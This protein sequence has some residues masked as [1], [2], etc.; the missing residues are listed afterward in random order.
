MEHLD[1]KRYKALR[2]QCQE[3]ALL[4]ALITRNITMSEHFGNA[5]VSAMARSGDVL[6][7]EELCEAVQDEEC[8]VSTQLPYDILSDESGAWED[9]C[10][11][12]RG[13]TAGLTNEQLTRRAH[14]RGQIHR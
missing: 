7:F 5:Y 4:A 3:R 8:G 9:P 1:R 6:G 11:L 14:A 13:Y 12:N 2:L 10:R